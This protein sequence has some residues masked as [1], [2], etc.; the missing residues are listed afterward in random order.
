MKESRLI[1]ILG[2]VQFINILD[3]MMVMPLGPDLAKGIGLPAHLIGIVGGS[4]TLAAA[5]AG[6]VGLLF[7]DKFQRRKAT[8]FCLAGLAIS[9]SLCALAWDLNSVIFAR[10]LAGLFGGPLSSLTL[11]IIADEIPVE[12]RGTVMGKIMGA[13]AAASVI[14]VPFG[15]ELSSR[16]GWRAPFISFGIIASLLWLYTYINLHLTHRQI[17]IKKHH[18]VIIVA[19]EILTNQM[20]L[21]MLA[22]MAFAMMAG[23]MIIPNI[24]A[25][26]QQNIGFPREYLGA[27]YFAGGAVSFFSMRFA[28]KLVDKY[29]SNVVSAFF[30]ITLIV[31]LLIGFVYWQYHLLPVVVIFIIFMVSM[32]GRNVAAQTLASKVPKPSHRASFMSLNSSITHMATSAGAMFSSHL[33]ID[34]DSKL[35]GIE[36]VAIIA[37]MLSIPV[38]ILLRFIEKLIKKQHV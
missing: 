21:A 2:L 22:V 34:Q 38:P 33:L 1:L 30:T 35:M 18:E 17:T 19:K 31:S 10:F 37:I 15:L 20:T 4:Y 32:T 13:F 12:R 24:S 28:G 16:F 3:F 8:L 11:A 26:L 14:G 6:L 25:H 5:L 27:L 7:L 36:T 23:F 29:S 9:T